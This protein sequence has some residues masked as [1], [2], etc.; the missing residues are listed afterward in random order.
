MPP[1]DQSA[2]SW[3][4]DRRGV[5]L[6]GPHWTLRYDLLLGLFDLEAPA[7]PQF[8]IRWARG[9]ALYRKGNR[10]LSVG[11][12]DGAN[13]TWQVEPMR[14]DHGAGLRLR[15]CSNSSRRPALELAAIVYAHS[16]L[17]VLEL[18]VH[19]SLSQE[20]T[21]EALRPLEIDPAWGGKLSLGGPVAG[22]YSAA[23]QSWGPAG[24]KS[25]QRYDLRTRYTPLMGPVLDAPTIPPLRRGTFRADLV[26]ALTPAGAGPALL[27]GQLTTADQFGALE[28]DLRRPRPT[29]AFTCSTDGVSLTPNERLASERVALLLA[30][31]EAGPLAC[32]GDALGLEMDGL[33]DAPAPT[34]WCSWTAFYLEL[35]EEDILNQLAWLQ[36]H[37]HTLPVDIV[38]I[39]DG[40]E[41]AVGDWEANE[42]FPHGMAWLAGQIRRAG[43]TPGLWLAPFIV[44]PRSSLATAHPEWLIQNERGQ[45]A[46]AG[47]GWGSLCHGLDLSHPAAQRWVQQ[48]IATVTE[49]W[50][51]AYLKLD[52]LYAAAIEGQRH[53]PNLTRAQVLR[54][55]MELLRQEAGPEVFLLGCGC[56]LGPAVGLVDAM[57]VSA[58]I[59]PYW[60]PRYGLLSP[61]VRREPS[62][63][64]M[65]NAVQNDLTQ[66]WMHR[67]LWLNDPDALILRRSGS[68][69]TTAE[70]RSLTTVVALS[71]GTWMLGDDM[72]ALEADRVDLAAHTLPLHQ[73][74]PTIPDVL[75]TEMPAQI[76]LRQEHP[77]GQG[78][79]VA[80]FNWQDRPADLAFDPTTLG[81]PADARCHCH[82]FW[83]ESYQ[84][85]Q[86]VVHFTQVPPHDCRVV[87]LQPVKEGP[88]WA[89]STLHLLQGPE[90]TAWRSDPGG[91]YL[92]LEAGRVLAGSVLL[93]LPEGEPDG[94]RTDRG[95]ARLDRVE[96]GLW[97][98]YIEMEA[99]GEGDSKITIEINV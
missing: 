29:L 83:T 98:L 75:G 71:G 95:S 26:G 77:W 20:I 49:E 81:F 56:P 84:Q 70:V 58:D 8:S 96:Q 41:R 55:G 18:T 6:K 25:A 40:W 33:G 36:E 14:D 39:D 88:Q 73:T 80:L 92:T 21:V 28:A 13:E 78:W 2:L 3:H 68:D 59:A 42:R 99:S 27:G 93:W 4:E 60:R 15:V 69:L 30:P 82:E 5:T 38:Q 9:Q 46:N 10:L 35:G 66:A 24:W 76:T 31:P 45:P 7:F 52:F 51:Y 86:G 63:P 61:F 50:G 47:F 94:V 74:Q 53:R 23:W 62:L 85:A 65:I 44:H 91:V 1:K 54:R 37:S 16:P 64:A 67:R 11:T 32:Y 90:V 89:G 79:V 19:N 43:F 72:P 12:D 97:R 22:L 17:L 57:R 48:L 34:G 87:L